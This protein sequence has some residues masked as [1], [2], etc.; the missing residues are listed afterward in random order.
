MQFTLILKIGKSFKIILTGSCDKIFQI[1]YWFSCGKHGLLLISL[2]ILVSDLK[3]RCVQQKKSP[4][5]N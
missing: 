4:K 1:D 3:P 2:M 5:E